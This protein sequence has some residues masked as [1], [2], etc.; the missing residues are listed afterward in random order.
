MLASSH[1][2]ETVRNKLC[3]P[4]SLFPC[5]ANLFQ[6]M[7]VDLAMLCSGQKTLVTVRGTNLGELREA[8]N[9]STEYV[10]KK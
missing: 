3:V 7:P 10:D 4:V 9:G 2:N 1:K 5:I 8:Q 6:P